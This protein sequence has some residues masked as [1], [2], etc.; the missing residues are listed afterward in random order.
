MGGMGSGRTYHL[1]AKDTVFSCQSIDIHYLKKQGLLFPGCSTTLSWSM[2]GR[3]TGSIGCRATEDGLILNYTCDGQ[4]IRLTVPIVYSS[5]NYGGRRPW[6]Q[7]P[8]CSF[9]VGKLM[10][11]GRTFVCRHCG[12]LAYKSQRESERDRLLDRAQTLRKRL[13]GTANT[14]EPIPWKPKGMHWK[15][16]WRLRRQIEEYEARMWGAAAKRFGIAL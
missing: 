11:V 1:G 9:R 14:F 3:R 15:T 5:C 7:C 13:G 4:S 10:G 2:N 16:Y 8:R 12:D 6:L